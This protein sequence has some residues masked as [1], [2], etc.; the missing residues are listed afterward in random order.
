MW[1]PIK[2]KTLE[3][4]TLRQYDQLMLTRRKRKRVLTFNKV[5]SINEKLEA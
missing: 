4:L 1:D 5:R 3:N 2:Q